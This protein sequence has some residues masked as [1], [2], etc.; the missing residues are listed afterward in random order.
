MLDPFLAR[1]GMSCSL[2]VEAIPSSHLPVRILVVILH[3]PH[4]VLPP[5]R[6]KDVKIIILTWRAGKGGEREMK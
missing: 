6:L 4:I 3:P 2:G 5:A 1:A